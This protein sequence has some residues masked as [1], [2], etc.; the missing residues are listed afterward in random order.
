MFDG[1]YTHILVSTTQRK[2]VYANVKTVINLW[3]ATNQHTDDHN[4]KSIKG[5]IKHVKKNM[6]Q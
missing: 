1:T 5:N 2:T 3:T 6:W 4:K